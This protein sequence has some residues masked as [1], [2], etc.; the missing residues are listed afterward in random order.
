MQISK[1]L[2]EDLTLRERGLLITIL[3]LKDP[4]PKITLAKL[5]ATVK[6]VEV[7]QDLVNLQERGYIKWSG[8]N[9]AVK[10]LTKK[11]L[12]PKVVTVINFM[13]ELYQR[14]FDPASESSTVN[15]INRLNENTLDD[16]LLVVSNRYAVWK[17]DSV[18][19]VHLNPTTIFRPSK[20]DKY[21]E[22]AKRTRK[23]ERFLNAEK[24]GLK[25]GDEITLEISKTL[26]NNEIYTYLVYTLDENER[27]VGKATESSR[28]GKQIKTA[29]TVRENNINAGNS[30]DFEYIYKSK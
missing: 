11:E 15:L 29:L 22:E 7:K 20:F 16:I 13:N 19:S 4:N 27:R 6:M 1:L 3:L 8:Y 9:D 2:N 17:D 30:K 28:Y 25:E 18:M 21:L 12:N 5:K 10:S 23:G 14:N 26:S 24:T